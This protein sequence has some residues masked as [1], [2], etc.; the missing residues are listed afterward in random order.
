MG[1]VGVPEVPK[2]VVVGVVGVEVVVEVVVGVVV[3]LV[4]GGGPQI[5]GGGRISC[6][7]I[8]LSDL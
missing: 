5:G 8:E 7:I 2:F 6:L 4:H 1:Q 3:V